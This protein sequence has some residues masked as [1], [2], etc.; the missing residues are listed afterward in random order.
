MCGAL[1][2]LTGIFA[3]G[4][5]P[6]GESGL[7]YQLLPVSGSGCASV[8]I[9]Y[10][11]SLPAAVLNTHMISTVIF[12]IVIVGLLAYASYLRNTFKK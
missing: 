11:Q 3:R 12:L 10:Y 7:V 4:A 6:I 5:K 8:L 2:N 9:H 1:P